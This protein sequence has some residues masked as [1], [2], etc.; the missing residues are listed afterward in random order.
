M[1]DRAFLTVEAP[2]WGNGV[3]CERN[4]HQH[5]AVGRLRLGV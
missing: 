1:N 5:T 4:E 3:F 2:G